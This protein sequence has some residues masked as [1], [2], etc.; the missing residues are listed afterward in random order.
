MKSSVA[1][2]VAIVVASP[3]AW[4][5]SAAPAD[6]APRIDRHLG[7]GYKIGNS[8]GYVGAD[9]ILSPIPH[10]ALDLQA[11]W[12]SRKL[13]ASGFGGAAGVHAYLYDKGRSTPYLSAGYVRFS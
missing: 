3:G 7:V 10:L 2:M 4:A 11:S 13:G 8:L 5:E 12:F 9:L 1:V 6:P